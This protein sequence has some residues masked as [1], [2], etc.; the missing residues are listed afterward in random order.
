M[1]H[2]SSLVAVKGLHEEGEE[3]KVFKYSGRDA[4]VCIRLWE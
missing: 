2:L 1:A 4:K 3:E